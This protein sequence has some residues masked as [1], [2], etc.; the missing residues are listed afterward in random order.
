[1]K[2]YSSCVWVDMGAKICS[3]KNQEQEKTNELF[4]TMASFTPLAEEVELSSEHQ[5]ILDSISNVYIIQKTIFRSSTL[6]L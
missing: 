2:D 1:M 4:P 6:V 3:Q 5:Y